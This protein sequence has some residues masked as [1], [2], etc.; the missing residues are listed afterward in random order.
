MS[1]LTIGKLAMNDVSSTA[2]AI[3]Y[4]TTSLIP[5]CIWE[6]R[7]WDGTDALPNSAPGGDTGFQLHYVYDSGSSGPGQWRNTTT[8]AG[9]NALPKITNWSAWGGSSPCSADPITQIMLYDG[10]LS[11]YGTLTYCTL[12]VSTPAFT[13]F[14]YDTQHNTGAGLHRIN[15]TMHGNSGGFYLIQWDFNPSAVAR[16][17]IVLGSHFGTGGIG[18]D[19]VSGG[20]TVT[21]PTTSQAGSST[22]LPCGATQFAFFDNW[23]ADNL[24]QSFFLRPYIGANRTT[25]GQPFTGVSFVGFFRGSP[26]PAAMSAWTTY[27]QTPLG[28]TGS[29]GIY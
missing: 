15:E 2:S 13:A 27:L 9:D 11:G 6:G 7:S 4:P 3:V 14:S 16:S 17:V 22:Q 23:T 26:T 12:A 25:I 8:Q 19:G 29:G 28:S 1:P 24:R 18:S 21:G 20:T 10:T 5:F